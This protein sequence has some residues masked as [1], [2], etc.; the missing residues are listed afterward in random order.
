MHRCVAWLTLLCL[1]PATA[2]A[3]PDIVLTVPMPQ[4]LVAWV[5][6]KTGAKLPQQKH[7]AVIE[8]NDPLFHGGDT[9]HASG[10]AAYLN[11]TIYF[12]I[13][14]IVHF[15]ELPFQALAIHELIH[16]AQAVNHRFYACTSQQETEAYSLQNQYLA[17]HGQFPAMAAE[18]IAELNKC[19]IPINPNH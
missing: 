14:S 16:A 3:N 17:E 10:D 12:P 15:Q 8:N 4:D 13:R 1:F 18:K 6:A 2:Y 7:I 19:Q 5:E 9:L 11:G